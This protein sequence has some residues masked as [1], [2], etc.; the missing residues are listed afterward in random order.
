VCARRGS[1]RRRRLRSK[2]SIN[3]MLRRCLRR[4]P[5]AFTH[6]AIVAMPSIHVRTST[7]VPGA[8]NRRNLAAPIGQKR[9]ARL[10]A[11]E[12]RRLHQQARAA[13]PSP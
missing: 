9:P 13:R 8:T 7:V 4:W 2:T 1:R 5:P 12:H 3:V 6:R 11:I 10:L